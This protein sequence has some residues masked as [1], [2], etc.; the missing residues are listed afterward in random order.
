M[1]LALAAVLLLSAV[2]AFA[3][4]CATLG[5]LGID[6]VSGAFCDPIVPEQCML[7]FP[8]DFFTVPDPTARTRRRINFTD[9]ALPKN[10]NGV[11]LEAAELNRADGFSPGSALLVW[12]ASADLALSDAPAIDDIGRSLESDSP[13]VVVDARNGKRVPLWAERDLLS[14]PGSQSVI[15]RPAIDFVDGRR[16]LVAVRHLVDA[17]G[18]ELSPSPA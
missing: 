10:I 11:P 8:N 6:S 7:P 9:E 2:P 12:M 14:P 5:E 17:G 1:R 16:Y 3:A 4:P 13:I 18:V 15:V